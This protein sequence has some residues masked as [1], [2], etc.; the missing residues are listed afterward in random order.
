MFFFFNPRKDHRGEDQQKR[1][2]CAIAMSDDLESLIPFLQQLVQRLRVTP[3]AAEIALL[4]KA[5]FKEM[6]PFFDALASG[7]SD[8]EVY[9][10]ILAYLAN[11]AAGNGLTGGAASPP[12][13]PA[14]AASSAA[15][16][17]EPSAAAPAGKTVQVRKL[18][19]DVELR[20]IEEGSK[21][22][23]ELSTKGTPD[24]T[25]LSIDFSESLNLA[26]K[27]EGPA[28]L[29][30]P[31]ILNVNVPTLENT[32]GKELCAAIATLTATQAGNM[33]L[34]YKVSIRGGKGAAPPAAKSAA[35]T[36]PAGAPAAA[37]SGEADD[38]TA[39]AD[40]LSIV[41]RSVE[42]GYLLFGKNTHSAHKYAVTVSLGESSNL[43]FSAIGP[44]KQL[45]ADKISF[46]LPPNAGQVEVIDCKVKDYAVGSC[47]IR[48]KVSARVDV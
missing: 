6:R 25:S 43:V 14:A 18:L 28:S 46:V 31:L 39:I 32:G 12:A 15:K 23:F 10:L 45:E 35:T 47:D 30:S 34:N 9:Q 13:K 11:P 21:F 5:T 7:R 42:T 38:V 48:Y 27:A 1:T 29:P 26:L 22:I 3:P 44:A 40:G 33:S 4:K 17:P 37:P 19:Q 36:T 8:T 24:A 2:R 41:V 20:V 16:A